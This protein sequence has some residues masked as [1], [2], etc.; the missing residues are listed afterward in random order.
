MPLKV[1][2]IITR[3]ELGGAQKNVLA[4]LANLPQDKYE[5]HLIASPGPLEDEARA[6]PGLRLKLLPFLRRRPNPVLDMLAFFYMVS[7][8][9]I[10]K[11]DIV[12]THSSKA[13]I[14]GR[15]AA[16]AAG[17]KVV[18][19]T[20]HGWG[21][22]DY[23]RSFFNDLYIILERLSAKITLKLIAVTESDIQKGLDNGIGIEKQYCLIRYGIDRDSF[24]SIGPWEALNLK[25]F[26][27]LKEEKVVGMVACLKPQK[28][29]LDFV[30]CARL[31]ANVDPRVKF[32]LAGD[33]ILRP[34]VEREIKRNDLS[35]DFF[36]LGWRRD[37]KAVISII[38][39][40]V[41][42]SLWEGSPLVFLEA[43]CLSKP[44]VAYDICGASELVKDNVNGFLVLPKD[45][46]GLALKVNLLLE[47]R[48]VCDRMKKFASIV[49]SREDLSLKFMIESLDKLYSSSVTNAG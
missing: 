22:H 13:G 36:L 30:R 29:P 26:L 34:Q 15:F 8:I 19:H 41:L 23:L 10:N 35:E 3:L 1:L 39:V 45:T 47:N 49:I 25:N 48:E 7:Y 27:G 20:I 18:F 38:D 46:E 12:H 32:L 31:I 14:L 4:M 17:V 11:I 42:T 33:G 40:L 21:F 24:K 44:I 16:R 37:I 2:H 28:N 9:R 5:I 43:M 6:I